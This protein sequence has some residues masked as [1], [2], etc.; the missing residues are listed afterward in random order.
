MIIQSTNGNKGFLCLTYGN[1]SDAR[2]E[3]YPYLLFYNIKEA[4]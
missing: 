3:Y 4:K 1:F 2:Y